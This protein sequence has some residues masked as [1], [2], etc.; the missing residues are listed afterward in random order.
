MGS[1]YAMSGD[2]WISGT[3]DP[4]VLKNSKI[5]FISFKNSEKTNLGIVKDARTHKHAKSQCKNLC[6]MSYTKNDKI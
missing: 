4:I 5:V 2:F 6:I 1:S 3:S